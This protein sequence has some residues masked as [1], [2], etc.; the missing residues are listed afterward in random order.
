MEEPISEAWS[1][2]LQ[3]AAESRQAGSPHYHA[4][5]VAK[6]AGAASSQSSTE[7]TNGEERNRATSDAQTRR[8][9]WKALDFGGQGLRALSNALFNYS[10]LTKLYLN[11]NNLEYLP[12]SIGRLKYLT[13]L[14]VSSNHLVELPEEM[15]MLINMETCLL[16]DNKVHDLP[17]ELGY[18]FK[19]NMLGIQGN[20]LKEELKVKIVQEGT[21]ALIDALREEMPGKFFRNRILHSTPFSARFQIG[22]LI[23]R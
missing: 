3:M 19:L 7:E 6:G 23:R 17:Y 2:Q 18:M 20:P 16:F 1:Q 9:G 13:H 15:G 10:F 21:R 14:D 5:T 8:Q 11:H 4:R 12:S 22:K